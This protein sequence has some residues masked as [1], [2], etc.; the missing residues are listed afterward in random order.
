MKRTYTVNLGGQVFNIDDD[1]FALL[2]NYLNG[3]HATFSGPDGAEIVADIEE[4]IREHFAESVDPAR[5]V[6]TIGI[7]N[8]IITTMGSPEQISENEPD[9]SGAAA[10]AMPCGTAAAPKTGKHLYRNL[11]NKVFGGVLGG[12]AAYLGWNAGIL[13]LLFVIAALFTKIV[14]F[15]ICYLVAWM[16]IPAAVT[17]LQKLRMTGAPVTLGNMGQAVMDEANP[18][19]ESRGFVRT[20]FTVIAKL[21]VGFVG[22]VSSFVCIGSVCMFLI[23]LSGLIS[24]AAFDNTRIIAGLELYRASMPFLGV[25]MLMAWALFSFLVSGAVTWGSACMIFNVKG[26]SRTTVIIGLI[27]AILLFCTAFVLTGILTASI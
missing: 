7:V 12:I 22:L 17:P 3:L 4:R 16:V 25:S 2:S 18:Q 10:F 5:G 11:Q 27:M 19:P 6:I 24:L 21:V 26:A 20:F 1:A 23:G 13:R 14:P 9:A 15:V 8:S